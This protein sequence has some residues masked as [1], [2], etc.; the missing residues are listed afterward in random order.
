MRAGADTNTA[1]GLIFSLV[2]SVVL[3]GITWAAK[4]HLFREFEEEEE[5]DKSSVTSGDD[6]VGQS[7]SLLQIGGFSIGSKYR[8]RST[9]KKRTQKKYGTDARPHTFPTS[10]SSNEV[11][12]S[13]DVVHNL[14]AT[15]EFDVPQSKSHTPSESGSCDRPPLDDRDDEHYGEGNG[16]EVAITM[17]NER[18]AEDDIVSVI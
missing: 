11:H 9:R 15:T 6:A 17:E 10:P 4:K 18:D 1:G 8:R 12:N 2:P 7:K 14:S 16:A 5:D 3:G 13:S